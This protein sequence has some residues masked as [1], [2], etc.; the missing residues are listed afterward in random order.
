MRLGTKSRVRARVL[1]ASPDALFTGEL[2]RRKLTSD[3]LSDTKIDK[4]SCRRDFLLCCTVEFETRHEMEKRE[5]LE[6]C[7]I[8]SLVIYSKISLS[9]SSMVAVIIAQ[10]NCSTVASPF[11]LNHALEILLIH[12]LNGFI[13]YSTTYCSTMPTNM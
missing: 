4:V 13:K 1:H 10:C 11:C 12:L 2:K 9:H 7:G 6:S 5:G 3:E 8:I